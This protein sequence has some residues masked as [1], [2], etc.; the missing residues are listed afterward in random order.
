MK[1]VYS[2]RGVNTLLESMVCGK[3]PVTEEC[4]HHIQYI[5]RVYKHRTAIEL[6]TP[7]LTR[8]LCRFRFYPV[9]RLNPTFYIVRVV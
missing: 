4:T 7:F 2:G 1:E 6:Q 8:V 3:R 5:M 9:H